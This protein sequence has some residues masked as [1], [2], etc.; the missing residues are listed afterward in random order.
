MNDRMKAARGA[1]SAAAVARLLKSACDRLPVGFALFDADLLLV[2]SNARFAALR[3]YPRKLA[4]AGTPLESLV[5][6]DAERGEYGAGAVGA[7]T[8]TRLA[9]LKRGRPAQR[10]Q[11]LPDARCLRIACERLP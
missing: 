8:R 6:F 9:A 4:K 7:L 3:G 2:A 10:E 1:S 11:A 5:R